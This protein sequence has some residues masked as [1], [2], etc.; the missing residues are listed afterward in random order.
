ME[1]TR[2]FQIVYTGPRHL[3]QH[4]TT[5]FA[6]GIMTNECKQSLLSKA[7]FFKH[8]KT[9]CSFF[10][11]NLCI[12]LHLG[13][14]KIQGKMSVTSLIWV[15][16]NT[17]IFFFFPPRVFFL[18]PDPSISYMWPWQIS[19][20]CLW[21]MIDRTGPFESSLLCCCRTPQLLFSFSL[22]LGLWPSESGMSK[23]VAKQGA[24]T[25]AVVLI[26]LWFM[27][28][29]SLARAR[30]WQSKGQKTQLLF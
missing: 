27:I 21:T 18:P 7:W 9:T 17:P 8:S 16:V 20:S 29:R 24:E 12:Q 30:K 1:K 25:I 5:D 22:C 10:V 15:V 23:K 26:M 28:L 11:F 4:S 19:T 6:R 13:D 2:K 14:G 3:C